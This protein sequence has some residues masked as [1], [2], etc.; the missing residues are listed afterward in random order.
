MMKTGTWR[1][2]AG[3]MLLA[4]GPVL[5]I[6]SDSITISGQILSQ[7]GQTPKASVS[8]DLFSDQRTEYLQ[9]AM[10]GVDG[11]FNFSIDAEKY[12]DSCFVLTYIAPEGEVI[13]PTYG[14]HLDQSICI[15]ERKSVELDPVAMIRSSSLAKLDLM[16]DSGGAFTGMDLTVDLFTANSSGKRVE[17]IKSE[18]IL[19]GEKKRLPMLAGCFVVVFVAPEQAKQSVF[20]NGTPFDEQ[21]FCIEHGETKAL[22]ANLTAIGNT[23]LRFSTNEDKFEGHDATVASLSTVSRGRS[24]PGKIPAIDSDDDPMDLYTGSYALV[25][26]LSK[27]TNG[28]DNLSQIPG[29]LKQVRDALEQHGFDV[30]MALDLPTKRHLEQAF[31]DFRDKY[32]Y[33][34]GNRLLVYYA[35]HGYSSNNATVGHLVAAD[36]PFPKTID[37]YPGEE[38]LKKSIQLSQMMEWAGQ[39][40]VKHALFLFDSC[41]SGMIFKSRGTGVGADAGRKINMQQISQPV[42]Q[43]ITSG[44]ADEIVPAKSVFVQVLVEALTT[45]VADYSNDGYLTGHELGFYLKNEVPFYSNQSPQVGTHTKWE[46]SRGDF[47]FS[48][49]EAN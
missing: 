32:G 25:V 3:L 28:W 21:P 35:G 7:I 42:R 8:V 31:L 30:T 16:V 41:F 11:K 34:P 13:A 44:S 4:S 29:E 5:A 43:F 45:D 46:F 23:D 36:A 37:G 27:Y 40:T 20:S 22:S 15:A 10:T 33:N 26:G 17:F 6:A 24:L 2:I 49:H 19:I 12:A 9:S 48:L 1:I 47:V 39:M 38:F 18:G 14:Q